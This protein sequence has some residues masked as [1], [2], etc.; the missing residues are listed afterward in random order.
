VKDYAAFCKANEVKQENGVDKLGRGR[1]AAFIAKAGNFV[2]LAPAAETVK[3]LKNDATADA[4]V[5]SAKL[6]AA[7]KELLASTDVFCHVN[8]PVAMEALKK[9]LGEQAKATTKAEGGE[10]PKVAA[11]TGDSLKGISEMMT[12][13][14]GDIESV[15]LGGTLG[16]KGVGLSIAISARDGTDAAKAIAAIKNVAGGLTRGLA[17][18]T[19][20]F[21]G[22]GTATSDA[23]LAWAGKFADSFAKLA[24]QDAGK[25]RKNMELGTKLAKAVK[26]SH[27]AVAGTKAGEK[28]GLPLSVNLVYDVTDAVEAR[29]L[30]EQT[31]AEME[32][33][34]GPAVFVDLEKREAGVKLPPAGDDKKPAPEGLKLFAPAEAE[35]LGELK[36]TK[37]VVNPKL[38]EKLPQPVMGIVTMIVG[39]NPT[40]R[41]ATVGN[42]LVLSAGNAASLT[43]AVD[44]AKADKPLADSPVVARVQD[45]MLPERT[46]E[47]YVNVG[48]IWS[49]VVANLLMPQKAGA[50]ATEPEVAG[51]LAKFAPP[52]NVPPVTFSVAGKDRT[53]RIQVSVPKEALKLFAL[54]AG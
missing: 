26:N 38:M 33:P 8:A 12:A 2:K 1:E 47:C 14:L 34:A 40:L 30:L 16:E 13:L 7:Q 53:L 22:G 11:G 42:K 19:W 27:F 6:T 28:L 51:E 37:F 31:W 18:D 46:M 9:L 25:L 21:A 20:L 54:L 49:L 52:A 29:K 44:A 32:L 50:A 48:G 45:Q 36:V 5:F 3:A 23:A 43:A 41:I 15:D 10:D 35:T 4:P 24:G 17:P 39:E